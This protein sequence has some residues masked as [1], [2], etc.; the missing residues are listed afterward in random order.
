M[1][2]ERICITGLGAVT[3]YGLGAERLW[4]ALLEGRDAIADLALFETSDCLFRRGGEVPAPVL[5]ELHAGWPH[6]AGRA[7]LLAAAALREALDQARLDAADLRVTAL[8]TA[9]NFDV[10]DLLEGLF[11]ATAGV[12]PPADAA[13]DSA[14]LRA[15]TN[16]ALRETFGLGGPSAALS[17]SC[18]S[19]AV[20]LARAAEW[21]RAGRADRVAVVGYDALSRFAWTGLSALRTMTPDAVRPFDRRRSGTLFSEGAAALVLER[22]DVAARRAAPPLAILQGW[23]TGNNGSHMTAPAPQGAGTADV[24]RR[25]LLRAGLAASAIDHFNAHGTGTKLND[26]T[27]AA[28]LHA[29]LGKA[30]GTVPTTSVKGA[31]GHLM[32]AAGTAEAIASVLALRDGC[33]PPTANHAEPDPECP[34]HV[35]VGEPLR[36]PLLA[37]LSNSAGIGGTN[38]ALVLTQPE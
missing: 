30:A 10:A 17:L 14:A 2:A 5:E 6:L 37:V 28:A 31:V 32:G 23:A 25:A 21:I 22:A 35:V 3:P 12:P 20:A 11:A 38:A 33:V 26:S 19:G 9:T 13:P 1:A 36:S 16:A 34:L 27:E 7:A 15:P 4:N 8:L 29:V 18:S 24:L